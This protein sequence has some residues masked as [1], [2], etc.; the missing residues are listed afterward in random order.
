MRNKEL[1]VVARVER[2]AKNL[3]FVRMLY[4][5]THEKEALCSPATIDDSRMLDV[6]IGMTHSALSD[7]PCGNYC[8]S[9]II[10]Y[11]TNNGGYYHG[12]YS[13]YKVPD[14]IITGTKS[15]DTLKDVNYLIRMISHTVT[16]NNMGEFCV[17]Y[18]G[19]KMS[20]EEFYEFQKG[21]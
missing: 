8:G 5:F 4:G 12:S 7:F 13:E 16:K 14:T 10:V 17:E 21:L 1:Y 20:A 2:D 19:K 15:A 18:E 9:T 11:N 6:L 3:F